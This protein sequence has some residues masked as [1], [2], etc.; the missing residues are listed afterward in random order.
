MRSPLC[1]PAIPV[2][3]LHLWQIWSMWWGSSGS[4]TFWHLVWSLGAPSLPFLASSGEGLITDSMPEAQPRHEQE[5]W[6]EKRKC[7]LGILASGRWESQESSS[8]SL[9]R[10]VLTHLACLPLLKP[11]DLL[12]GDCAFPKTLVRGHDPCYSHLRAGDRLGP[13]LILGTLLSGGRSV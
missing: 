12:C 6:G 2:C 3:L 1:T 10:V 9:H 8:R 4:R 5:L 7:W 11:A 13:W